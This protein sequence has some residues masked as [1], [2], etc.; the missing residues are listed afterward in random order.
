M[1]CGSSNYKPPKFNPDRFSTLKE[2][3]TAIQQAGLES[4][5]LIF[6]IDYTG[7]NNVTGARTFGGKCLHDLSVKNPYME[8]IEILGETL[9]PFDDDHLI[10][11]Y[12]FGDEKSRDL[13]V[14]P[15]Y[16][17]RPCDGF[18]EVLRRYQEITPTIDLCGPT[19]FAPLIYEA[20]RI[21]KETKQYHILVIVTDGQV[22]SEK[23]TIDAIVEA[24]KTAL[25]IVCIGVGD[26]PWDLMETFDD[27]I[28][29][30]VFDNFQFVDFHEVKQRH[31]NNF[32]PAFALSCLMEIPDQYLAIKKLGYLDSL[33]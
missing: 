11:A 23:R 33:T 8:V 31:R 14:M 28:P 20:I 21:V 32:I 30:R 3:Q 16:P 13:T 19:D 29:R 12:G 10:P 9:E 15:F 27:R 2:V 24:S 7:S 18:Q 26:G 4:S 22:N 6:G 1:G 17:D 25:S 5:N